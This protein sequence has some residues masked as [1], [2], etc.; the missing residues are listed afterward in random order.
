MLN[1]IWQLKSNFPQRREGAKFFKKEKYLSCSVLEWLFY[2]GIFL[3]K[4][5]FSICSSPS[6]PDRSE[7]L[8]FC[9]LR[10]SKAT[11]EKIV[12][13]SRKMETKNYQAIRY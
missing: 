7:N 11:K 2:L 10:L 1:V 6:S 9:C 13:E 5:E 12:T 4:T 8:F 3:L